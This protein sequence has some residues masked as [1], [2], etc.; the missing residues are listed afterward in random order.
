LALP[1]VVVRVDLHD[2]AI[3]AFSDGACHADN[4]QSRLEMVGLTCRDT[5]LRRLVENELTPVSQGQVVYRQVELCRL[6][7]DVS[8]PDRCVPASKLGS[9]PR[10]SLVIRDG[11]VASIGAG[12]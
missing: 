5:E 6:P 7:D 4:L 12:S 3:R 2:F 1:D 10:L 8:K 11:T 9:N